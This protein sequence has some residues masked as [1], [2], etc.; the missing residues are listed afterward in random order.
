MKTSSTRHDNPETALDIAASGVARVQEHAAARMRSKS[1]APLPR[2]ICERRGYL[3]YGD[4]T[5]C[6]RT[7]C[8]ENERGLC[9]RVL[10]DIAVHFGGLTQTDVGF[11]LGVSNSRIHQIERAALATLR[12]RTA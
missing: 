10:V 2:D 12:R 3:G 11:Y 8:V 5:T 6:P 1:A 7:T 9:G 4:R